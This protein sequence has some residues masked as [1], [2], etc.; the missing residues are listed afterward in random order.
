MVV[1]TLALG[2]DRPTRAD[3]RPG[4][5]LR[6]ESPTGPDPQR[7]KPGRKR[8]KSATPDVAAPIHV[9]PR[10]PSRACSGSRAGNR[11]KS[12]IEHASILGRSHS[13]RALPYRSPI[14]VFLTWIP[15]G[16]GSCRRPSSMPSPSVSHRGLRLERA[17]VAGQ[18][19]WAERFPRWSVRSGISGVPRVAVGR[20]QVQG[21][22]GDSV[23]R[24]ASGE[25][26]V[27]LGRPAVAS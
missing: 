1:S 24:G 2:L 15:Q 13:R 20:P 17:D 21:G 9:G 10:C 19:H 18:G 6:H 7:V 25:E 16:S 12:A 4:S 14:G 11:L 26:S 5:N 27:G 8:L 23:D 22:R 3:E